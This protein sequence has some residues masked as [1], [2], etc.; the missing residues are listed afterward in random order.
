MR[1]VLPIA[2]FLA[3]L[4]IVLYSCLVTAGREDDVAQRRMEKYEREDLNDMW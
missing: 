1:F 2:L 4:L 3:A